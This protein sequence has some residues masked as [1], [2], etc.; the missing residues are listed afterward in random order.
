MGVLRQNITPLRKGTSQH[1][2]LSEKLLP[3]YF[4]V[5]E[6]SL[7]DFLAFISA[8]AAKIDF[9]DDKA[10]ENQKSWEGFFVKD[11][12]VILAAVVSIDVDSIDAAFEHLVQKV[13][14]SFESDPK[15][16][17]FED[18]YDFL[19]DHARKLPTW[20]EQVIRLTGLPGTLENEVE[21]ELWKVY[22]QRLREALLLLNACYVQA[23]ENKLLAH[24]LSERGGILHCEHAGERVYIAGNAVLYL[25]GKIYL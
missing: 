16:K 23:R 4:Q 12:T 20:F 22:D 9:F 8:Y 18:L 25:K 21:T 19:V 6:R 5:D 7:S 24:Q 11:I 17:H 14:G 13:Q 2:R 3:D 15:L 10:D 1:T